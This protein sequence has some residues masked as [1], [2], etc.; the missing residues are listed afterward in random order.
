M[1]SYYP[2][3]VIPSLEVCDMHLIFRAHGN[4]QVMVEFQSIIAS[5]FLVL[6]HISN[7]AKIHVVCLLSVGKK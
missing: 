6:L 3:A 2:A 5:G 7:V 4:I 1:S